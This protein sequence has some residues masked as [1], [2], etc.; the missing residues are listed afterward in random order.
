M[1]TA[2]LGAAGGI[3]QALTAELAARGHQVTAVSRTGRPLPDV[4]AK[5]VAADVYDRPSTA[6]AC[7]DA[8]VVVLAA[9]PPYHAWAG[10]FERMLDVVVAVAL[11]VGARVVFVDNLYMYGPADGP[12][13]ERSPEHATGKG[14]LRRALARRLLED[15][16]LSVTVGRASDYYGPGGTNSFLHSMVFEPALAGRTARVMLAGDQPHTWHYL[17][18]LA[19]SFATL[20]EHPDADGRAWVL[21]AAPPL[22][23]HEVIDIVGDSLE[24]PVKTS[25]VTPGLLAIAS[26]VSRQAR[27]GRKVAHQFDRPWVADSSDFDATFGPMELTSHQTAIPTTLDWLRR[28]LRL[29]A[30]A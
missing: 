24:G 13:S 27:E 3:G 14:A 10:N 26:L 8:E 1:R 28:Q 15:D 20:V 25:T 23:Q 6:A 7:A 21:P 2:V 18:D 11:D 16:R 5:P 17:P 9:M 4:Q 12:I 30:S 22:T 29:G 19:R